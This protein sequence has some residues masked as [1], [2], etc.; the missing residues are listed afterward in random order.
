MKIYLNKIVGVWTIKASKL[1]HVKSGHEMKCGHEEPSREESSYLASSMLPLENEY[2]LTLKEDDSA[3][4][5]SHNGE[6]HVIIYLIFKS[7]ILYLEW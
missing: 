7:I 3:I 5:T 4:I 1:V 2:Q 6:V